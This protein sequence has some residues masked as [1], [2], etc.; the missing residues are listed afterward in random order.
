MKYTETELGRAYGMALEENL[1]DLSKRVHNVSYRPLPK[2]E[3]LIP[4]DIEKT[5]PIAIANFEDK[6]VN[7]CVGAILTEV[8]ELRRIPN[9]K[10]PPRSEYVACEKVILPQFRFKP[11]HYRVK[12]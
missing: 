10:S 9:P 11:T 1:Q 6:L 8:Y 12:L 7:W 4:K 2:R 5:S 3:V